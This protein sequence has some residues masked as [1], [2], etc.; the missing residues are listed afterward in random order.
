MTKMSIRIIILFIFS[1]CSG[2]EYIIFTSN[3]AGHSNIYMMKNDGSNVAQLTGD[4]LKQ[5]SPRVVNKR[6]IS[7]L[8]EEYGKIKRYQLHLRT[9][10]RQEIRHPKACTLDK[11]NS[12]LSPN[13]RW[14]AY[15][16]NG[17]IYLSDIAFE[18]TRNLTQSIHSE[19]LQPSWFPDNQKIAFVSNRDGNLEI[20]TINID[21]TDLKNISNSKHNEEMPRVSPDGQKILYSSNRNGNGNQQIYMHHLESGLIEDITRSNTLVNSANWSRNGRYIYYGSN[22]DGNWEIYS[23]NLRSKQSKNITNNG[24]FDGDP[25]VLK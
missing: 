21:G 23:Y 7:F 11:K 22:H 9:K 6:E 5:W 12:I 14:Q 10:E 25:Q 4:D 19:D 1:G 16:C 15:V 17:D 8:A 3:R 20:Y 13:R 18:N 24:A 2:P